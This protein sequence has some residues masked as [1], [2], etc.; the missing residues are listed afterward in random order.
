MGRQVFNLKKN[1]PSNNTEKG[2][3][4]RAG[5]ILFELFH[6]D[7]QIPNINNRNRPFS[8]LYFSDKVY[9]VQIIILSIIT[10]IS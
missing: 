7:H 10:L 1:R 3:F 4:S 6:H 2:S 8:D 9:F 5:N